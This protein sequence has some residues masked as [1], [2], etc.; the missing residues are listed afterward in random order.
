M[1]KTILIIIVIIAFVNV[2]YSQEYKE[3][4]STINTFL[5]TFDSGYYGPLSVDE[6]Y[7]YCEIKGGKQSKILIS[8]ISEA[9]VVTANK[10]VKIFCKKGDCVIGVTGGKYD[11][12]SFRTEEEGFDSTELAFLLNLLIDALE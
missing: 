5:R 9:K 2:T 12:L 6:E 11:S 1:K 8:G 10:M 7:I 3:H 4:L